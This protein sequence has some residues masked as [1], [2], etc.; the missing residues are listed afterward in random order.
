MDAPTRRTTAIK[1]G[2]KTII[3]SP[4][5]ETAIA[6]GGVVSLRAK[7]REEQGIPIVVQRVA[8]KIVVRLGT[9]SSARREHHIWDVMGGRSSL[10]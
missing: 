7:E 6:K 3:T 5:A 4:G 2:R 9:R 10:K 1:A 8:E